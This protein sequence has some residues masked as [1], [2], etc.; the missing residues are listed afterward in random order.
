MGSASQGLACQVYGP[1]P[2]QLIDGF[3][4]YDRVY[5]LAAHGLGKLAEPVKLDRSSRFR[6]LQVLDALRCSSAQALDELNIGHSDRFA[7]GSD[8]AADRRY[9]V[10]D[11]SEGLKCF[12]MLLNS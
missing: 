5:E 6:L 12:L 7:N 2:A 4:R 9:D 3:N 11:P 8:P 1:I 10:Q